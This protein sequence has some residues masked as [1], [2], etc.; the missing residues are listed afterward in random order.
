V[1]YHVFQLHVRALPQA[2]GLYPAGVKGVALGAT[3]VFLFIFAPVG[4]GT[5][6]YAQF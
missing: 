1:L 5:F 6:I 2:S 3:I 4:A